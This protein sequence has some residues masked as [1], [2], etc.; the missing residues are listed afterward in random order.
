MHSIKTYSGEI[1]LCRSCGQPSFTDEEIGH[2]HFNE[3]WDGIFCP[4]F[5]LAGD[6]IHM[7]WDGMALEQV[8]DEYPDT[9]PHD[10]PAA[11]Q[12]S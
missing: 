1:T 7:Q 3:Q 6:R 12:Q 2:Q 11:Q 8:R 5:P 4:H 9:Y 10:A